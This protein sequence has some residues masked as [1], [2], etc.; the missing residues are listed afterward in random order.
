MI[1]RLSLSARHVYRAMVSSKRMAHYENPYAKYHPAGIELIP[2][3]HSKDPY[4]LD[5][6]KIKN[7]PHH[8]L[9]KVPREYWPAT[10]NEFPAPSG[11]WAE[12]YAEVQ[13]SYNKQLIGGII[14]FSFALYTFVSNP[15]IFWYSPPLDITDLNWREGL[16]EE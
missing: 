16:E 2:A 10:L 1:P 6:E 11:S 14:L 12:H 5:P 8:T 7:D 13:S 3:H 9:H 15:R 4:T